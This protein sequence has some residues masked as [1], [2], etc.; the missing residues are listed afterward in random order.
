MKWV[1]AV[2]RGRTIR[3][4][5]AVV[6]LYLAYQI[7]LN[8]KYYG[9][10]W[11]CW[12]YMLISGFLAFL[13]AISLASDIN[14]R[15]DAA[16]DRLRLNNALI[17]T[18]DGVARLKEDMAERGKTIQIWSA[19]V[20]F[21]LIFGS[22]V[23]VF[24]TV[25]AQ[26]WHAWRQGALPQGGVALVE[27]GIFTLISALAAA[28]AGLFF[29]RLA[30]YGTLASVL[31]TDE[32][33]L[34]IVPGHFDGASGLKPIGDFYLYQALLFAIPILWFG[35]WWAWI[36]PNYKDVIC[37]V[38]GQPQF[39]F[40][41]WQEPFFILWLVV[42]GYF[43]FAFVRPFWMLRR[44]LRTTRADLNQHEAVRIE[45]EILERQKRLLLE[46]SDRRDDT[47]DEI[48]RLSR[49][50]WSIRTMTDWPMDFSTLAKYRSIVLGEVLLP[51]AAAAVSSFDLGSS[52]SSALQWIHSWWGGAS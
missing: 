49:H 34:R 18:E 50:L 7:W 20:I 44:R 31:S 40:R 28:L 52:G 29:G 5:L 21:S 24:G 4:F 23:W 43:Y 48:D 35:L 27:L 16:I 3:W 13:V 37:S 22:Y 10:D 41:E 19:F 51:L 9:T 36:I 30:H 38:T 11:P 42:L 32:G 2:L 12:D 15:L 25:A 17:V 6:A 14:R 33:R 26:I 39:L 46:T 1:D 47:A 8:A 45:G